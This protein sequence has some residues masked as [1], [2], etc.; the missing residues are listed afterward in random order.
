MGLKNR[1]SINLG[2][3]YRINISKSG[4]GYS[5]GTEGYRITKTAKGAAR[6][7][8]SVPGTGISDVYETGKA[9]NKAGNAPNKPQ[10]NAAN[11]YYDTQAIENNV[12][13]AM[14]SDG[15]EDMLAAAKKAIVLDRIANIGL[16]VS[17]FLLPFSIIL[18]AAFAALKIFVRIK[19]VLELDYSIDD[20]QQNIVNKR[21]N[22]MVGITT[23]A[24]VWRITQT[25][26]VIDRK[27]SGGA[28][29]SVK[30]TS[31][32][33]STQIPFPFKTNAQ[34]AVF[35]LKKETLIFLPDKLFVKQ[36]S[37]IGVLNYSDISTSA[38]TTRFQE[39]QSI[40]VD[41]QVIDYT[42]QF[43]NKSGG[44]DKRF[45]NNKQ[46]P[47]CLYGELELRS[48]SGLNTMIMF[49]NPNAYNNNVQYIL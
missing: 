48:T 38:Y 7:T 1:K 11:N 39:S 46:I 40:P 16:L 19:G 33:A 21:I 32:K 15:L 31:C 27:Y 12:A 4:I 44:P 2:G 34:C 5:L 45:S 22:P 10:Y 8:S 18:M 24:K 35:K 3:G 28:D 6:R 26:K 25:S 20:D 37:K 47:I 49:S 43:V 14:V 30:R 41:S 42:W 23:C 13:T 9:N 36:G 29:T 17:V